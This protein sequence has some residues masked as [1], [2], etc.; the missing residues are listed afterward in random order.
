MRCSA[1]LALRRPPGGAGPLRGPFG[2]DGAVIGYLPY[3]R[4]HLPEV[5]SL[6]RAEGWPS[7][8]ADP[9]R[10]HRALSAPGV[11]TLVAEE[12]GSVVGFACL[13]SDGEVQAH[14]SLVAV[15][16]A[17]RR[18]GIT[19]ALLA[20]ALVRAGGERVDLVTDGAEAFYASLAHRRMSGF[21][22][23]PLMSPGKGAGAESVVR[24]AAPADRPWVTEVLVGRWG[25]SVIVS[26][27]RSH[28]AS[29]LAALVAEVDGERLGLATYRIEGDEME[30]VTLDALVQGRGVGSAL[31]HATRQ[32]GVSAGCRRLWLVTTND[33][34]DALR[35]YQRRGMRVAAVH[36]GAADAARKTKPAIPEVGRYSIAVHDEIELE[37]LLGES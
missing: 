28:E 33:N 20:E 1:L 18:R 26:R 15:D 30:L 25:A 2:K 29:R 4:A 31:L 35:F 9:E 37:L 12:D 19:R 36:R 27:G 23:Y 24:P 13:Q 10:A 32:R 22:V 11:T 3:E 16:A 34:L 17:H 6:C 14:L 21:R 8:P 5:V 7:F